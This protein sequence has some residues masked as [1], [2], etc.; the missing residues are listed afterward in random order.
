V[1]SNRFDHLVS[2]LNL[3]DQGVSTENKTMQYYK[4]GECQIMSYLSLL[5]FFSPKNH[6]ATFSFPTQA[7][8]STNPLKPSDKYTHNLL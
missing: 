2:N 8:R 6:P 1:Y 3:C 4:F 7:L 5:F